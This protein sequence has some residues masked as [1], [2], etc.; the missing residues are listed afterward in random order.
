MT[1][2][3]N[4]WSSKN[5]FEQQISFW[6]IMWDRDWRVDAENA[7]FITWIKYML[8][9]IKIEKSYIWIVLEN[10]SVLLYSWSNKCSLGEHKLSKYNTILLTSNFRMV[11]CV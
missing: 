8:E 10:N 3:K 1:C 5:V 9:Y 11:V 6:R 2:S 7:A 4:K